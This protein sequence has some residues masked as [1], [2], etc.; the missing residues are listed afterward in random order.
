VAESEG[1]LVV[2]D[3]KEERLTPRELRLSGS[4]TVL[5]VDDSPAVRASLR[6]ILQKEGYRLLE[7]DSGEAAMRMLD[8]E[9]VD[10]LL[11]DL[12]MPG[13][14][15][16]ELVRQARNL[17]PPVETIVFTAFGTVETAVEVMREGACDF[18]TKPI[19]RL[20][21]LKT[22]QKALETKRL[23]LENHRLRERIETLQTRN[24]IIGQSRLIRELFDL[25]EQ[26]APS[27]AT[28]L[29]QGESGTG[30]ELI[31]QTLHELS[32]RREKPF[33]KVSC[34]ALPE[35]LLEAELFGY[36]KGAFTGAAQRKEGRFDLADGGTLLLD[37]IG[38]LP[39]PMQVKLLRVLQE[40]EYERVG[41]TQTL[42]VD[43]RI[44]AATNRDLALEV[45]ARHFREDLFYRLNVITLNLPPLRERPEDVPLLAEHFL[46]L[47]AR[48]NGRDS[49]ELSRAAMDLLVGYVWPGNVREL[50]NAMER[51][52]ILARKSVIGPEDF[53]AR[54][55]EQPARSL[56]D[57]DG[58]SFRIGTPLEVIERTMLDEVLRHTHGDKEAAASLLGISSRTIYRKLASRS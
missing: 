23:R 11:T 46:R 27:R 40:G 1:V 20:V 4:G 29:L 43:V 38:D 45:E 18:I 16:L 25:I 37:E 48:L 44:I 22:V 14:D 33:V 42:R 31:A 34:A 51:A 5:V 58:V 9:S 49:L 36:E 19:D 30:K 21:L 26:V 12:R 17:R 52:V 6:K 3:T 54:I 56:V 57:G 2:E 15:G 50:E 10:L 8:A 55:R 47:Y 24:R 53:P 7:A 35:T 39:L 13:L 41:G 28:V 32:M